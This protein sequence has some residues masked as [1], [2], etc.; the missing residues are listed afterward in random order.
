LKRT[1]TFDPLSFKKLREAEKNH[2]WF[3]IRNKCIFDRIYKFAPP[4]AK[5]LEVGCGTGNVSSFLAIKGYQVTGCE[6]FPEALQLS[7]PDHVKV[8]GDANNL[9]FQDNSFDIV[10]LFDVIEHFQ[11]D[12]RILKESVRVLKKNGIIAVTVPAGEELWSDFDT[13]SCHKRRYT[14]EGLKHILL[15]ARLK[16]FRIDYM[17]MSLYFPMKYLR[18][19]GAQNKDY[20]RI[21]PIMNALLK[22]VCDFERIISKSISLPFGTSIMAIAA[23]E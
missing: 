21:N 11:N 17:F 13:A 16:P 18:R 9:A 20:F 7:W 1:D 23:K 19:K 4:P 14:R 22:G 6:F 15:Q 12:V 10:G 5:L 3:Q 8:Q 2:F